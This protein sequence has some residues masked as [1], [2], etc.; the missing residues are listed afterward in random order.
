MTDSETGGLALVLIGLG[1]YLL[2][3]II[4]TLRGKANGS[5]GV[6]FVNVLLGWTLI[7]WLVSFIWACSGTTMADKRQEERRHR[8]LL[9]VIGAQSQPQQP[10]VQPAASATR[11]V[12]SV[13]APLAAM[14]AAGIIVLIAIALA[15][16]S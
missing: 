13:L 12:G 15:T 2:P 10:Q 7:G 1:C 3:S 16:P 9:A 5:T 14:F 11:T 8:E 4:A 6:F